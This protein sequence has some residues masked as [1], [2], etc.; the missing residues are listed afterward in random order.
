MAK[1][2]KKLLS[3]VVPIYKEEGNIAPF[4][5]RMRQVLKATGLDYEIIFCMD[6]SPDRTEELVKKALAKDRRIRLMVFARRF[7]QPAATLAG[8]NEARGDAVVVIDVDLQDPPE[9]IIEMVKRWQAGADVVYAKR[10]SRRGETLI[11]KVVSAFGYKLINAA[12]DVAI[13]R[14]TG[15]FRLLSRRVVDALKGLREKHGFLRGLVAYV[16]YRQEAIEFERPERHSGQG[17]YNRYLGS[18]RIG[19]NG[20]VG[21]SNF[22]LNATM[23]LGLAVA[24]LSFVGA[25]YIVVKR[26]FMGINYAVGIPT[27]HILVLFMGGAQLVSVGIL[28]QYIGRIYDEVKDRPRYLVDRAYNMPV[29]KRPG[30]RP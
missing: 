13:P 17:N 9:L 6:P 19:F 16:G 15:D 24:A 25:V 26:F 14:D 23:V 2:G 4:L 3:I 29:A 7:G 22:L 11:K 12:S 20:L 5:G 21:F 1:P 10:S 30:R 8:L 18:L 27:L 28:G